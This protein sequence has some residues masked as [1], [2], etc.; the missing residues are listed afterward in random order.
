MKKP[1]KRR[2]IQGR[3]W[4]GWVWKHLAKTDSILKYGELMHW[5]EPMEPKNSH[6][7]EKGKWI[8]VKFVEVEVP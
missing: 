3:D 2:L 6:P 1:K 8:R 4:H 5:A 7:T